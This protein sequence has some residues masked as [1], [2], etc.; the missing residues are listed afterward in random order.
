M[1]AREAGAGHPKGDRGLLRE[2]SNIKFG[3]IA[4]HWA[5]ARLPTRW[6]YRG[7]ASKPGAGSESQLRALEQTLVEAKAATAAGAA[8]PKID[9][10]QSSPQVRLGGALVESSARVFVTDT[11]TLDLT[12]SEA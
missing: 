10:L 9:F 11:Q 6:R 4:K 3:C 8:V 7:R 12:L 1:V 2:G 5:V